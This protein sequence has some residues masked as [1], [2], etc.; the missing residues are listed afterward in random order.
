M[1]FDW[2]SE[3]SAFQVALVHETAKRYAEWYAGMGDDWDRW[4]EYDPKRRERLID[5][6][7]E[8]FLVSEEAR[9][10]LLRSGLKPALS[11]TE[12]ES[13]AGAQSAGKPSDAK[14]D[15]KTSEAAAR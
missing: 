9:F 7:A 6:I 15:Q 4:E 3:L 12:H 8:I 1:S 11:E 2:R 5:Q 14:A 13:G 10:A